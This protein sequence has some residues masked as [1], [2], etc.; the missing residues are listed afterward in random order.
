[1]HA[2]L[3]ARHGD[4][5]LGAS[6]SIL[7]GNLAC[8]QSWRLFE[9][10]AGDAA[11]RE[12]AFRVVMRMHEEVLIG[13]ELDLLAVEDVSRMQQLKTGSYTLRGPIALGAAL[14]GANEAQERALDRFA[15]PLGEAF[16]MR[17]DLLGT[18]GD[19]R[20]TGKPAGNDLRAGKRTALIAAAE[21]RCTAADLAPLHAVLGDARATDADVRRAI[22]LLDRSGARVAAEERLDALL[23]EARAPLAGAPLS[24][25]GVAMLGDLADKLAHR[26]A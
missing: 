6:L 11:L 2:S 23:G 15:T 25:P 5:H 1:V 21:A 22:E 20:S 4:A 26:R 24:A 7:A 16:Q 8:A 10:A 3:G 19:T 18:F 9:G 14:G 12:R 13:Q 17:D